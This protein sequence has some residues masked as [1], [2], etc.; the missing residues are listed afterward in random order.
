MG[1]YHAVHMHLSLAAVLLDISSEPR[2]V[3]RM[4]L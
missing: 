1:L 3:Y 4:P 2:M